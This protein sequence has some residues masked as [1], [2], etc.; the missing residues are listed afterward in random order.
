VKFPDNLRT[1]D[2]DGV[3]KPWGLGST[4]YRPAPQGWRCQC[5]QTPKGFLLYADGDEVCG[6]CARLWLDEG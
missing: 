6:D 4:G 2:I 1:V 3:P 5:G